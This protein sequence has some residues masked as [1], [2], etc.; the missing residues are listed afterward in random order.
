MP[1]VLVVIIAKQSLKIFQTCNCINVIKKNFYLGIAKCM[2]MYLDEVA[3][4]KLHH[5][6]EKD[7]KE[8]CPRWPI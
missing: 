2:Y 5:Y 6:A 4:T 3:Y 1:F 7:K 8:I